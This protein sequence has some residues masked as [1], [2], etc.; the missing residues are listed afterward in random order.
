MGHPSV[1]CDFMWLA[2]HAVA[3]F[4]SQQKH[5]Y[6]WSEQSKVFN[7]AKRHSIM[8]NAACRQIDVNGQNRPRMQ[9]ATAKRPKTCRSKVCA[10]MHSC[11][12]HALTA[13]PEI[14]AYSALLEKARTLVAHQHT[15]R[16]AQPNPVSR[17]CLL[18]PWQQSSKWLAAGNLSSTLT[19]T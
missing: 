19:C 10:W 4:S 11:K 7:V 3:K 18:S 12:T 14:H 17:T 9:K 6:K 2:K 5:I 16:K 1:H 15:E 13:H 8:H